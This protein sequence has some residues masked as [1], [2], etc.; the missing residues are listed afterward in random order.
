MLSLSLPGM[1]RVA[2]ILPWS[3][4]WWWL[5]C[6]EVRR[7]LKFG[8]ELLTSGLILIEIRLS[9]SAHTLREPRYPRVQEG[10][11]AAGCIDRADMNLS[12]DE[13]RR[14]TFVH[15]P[16]RRVRPDLETRQSLWWVREIGI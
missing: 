7:G 16:N 5:R 3:S 12:M 1:S 2:Q 13:R 9:N 10:N 8:G 15:A 4:D 14:T 11:Y 6:R